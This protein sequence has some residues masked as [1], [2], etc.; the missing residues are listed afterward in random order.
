M[1]GYW[2]LKLGV[3][4]FNNPNDDDNNN[5]NNNVIIKIFPPKVNFVLDEGNQR[6][7]DRL[8]FQKHLLWI[9]GTISYTSFTYFNPQNI[10]VK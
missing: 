7:I 9:E 4:L 5:N 10:P 1:K 3:I 8:R 6:Y 2:Y